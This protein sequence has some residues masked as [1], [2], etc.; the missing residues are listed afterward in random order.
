MTG[1]YHLARIDQAGFN[2]LKSLVKTGGG[3]NRPT[4]SKDD[5]R[6]PDFAKLSAFKKNNIIHKAEY[7]RSIRMW[8]VYHDL[9]QTDK[10]CSIVYRIMHRRTSACELAV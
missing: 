1:T 3:L 9:Y 8:Q 6:W 10:Y 5:S 2:Q 7:F 4:L